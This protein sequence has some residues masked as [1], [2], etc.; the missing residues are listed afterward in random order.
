M[1]AMIMLACVGKSVQR[2]T[3]IPTDKVAV[4]YTADNADQ[5]TAAAAVKIRYPDCTYYNIDNQDSSEMYPIIN[6]IDTGTYHRIYIICD[7]LKSTLAFADNYVKGTLVRNKLTDGLHSGVSGGL[8]PMT[9][10]L[11]VTATATKSKCEVLWAVL[12][13]STTIPL[14]VEYNGLLSFSAVRGTANTAYTDSTLVDNTKTWT[15]DQ[16]AGYYVYIKA[17]VNIGDS[18]LIDSISATNKLWLVQHHAL[19]DGPSTTRYWKKRITSTSQYVIKKAAESNE[20]FYDKYSELYVLAYL[21]DLTS[22]KTLDNWKKLLN[23]NDNLNDATVRTAGQDLDYL[24]NTVIAGGKK[25]VDYLQ[26]QDDQ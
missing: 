17:G 13:P 19:A 7:T 12:Y 1:I 3:V 25:M 22:Q 23:N 18:H 5:V 21:S 20:L 4:L 15:T 6:A 14:I 10:P 8:T 11:I 16:Y 26:Q 24:N 2:A 9:V